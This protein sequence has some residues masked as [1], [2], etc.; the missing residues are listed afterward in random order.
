MR[1]V[2]ASLRHTWDFRHCDLMAIKP[3]HGLILESTHVLQIQE[4]LSGS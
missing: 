1:G 3:F 4:P 2:Q